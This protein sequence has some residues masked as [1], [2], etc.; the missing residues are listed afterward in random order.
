MDASYHDK[1]GGRG[2]WRSVVGR[3]RGFLGENRAALSALVLLMIVEKAFIPC[4]QYG[5]SN[6]DD[7]DYVFRNPHVVSGFRLANLR[8]AFSSSTGCNWH[9]VTM[10]SHMLDSQL[11]GMRPSGHHLTSVVVHCVNTLLLFLLLGRL[12]GEFWR[13]FWASLFFGVHPLRAES[14]VWISER[15]DVLSVMFFMLAVLAYAAYAAAADRGRRTAFYLLALLSFLLGLMSKP[16]LVTFPLLLL[17]LDY[18]PLRRFQNHRPFQL[19]WEK[20]PMF[21]LSAVFSVVTLITQTTAPLYTWPMRDRLANAI[22]AYCRYVGKLFWPTG[23]APFYPV[24]PWWPPGIVVGCLAFLLG[25]SAAVALLRKRTPF[26]IVGWAWFLVAL[27]PVIG[28]VQVGRQSMADRYSYLPSI[29][30]IVAVVW[31]ACEMRGR[32]R[33]PSALFC[34]MPV[35]LAAALLV[36]TRHQVS[37]WSSNERLWRHAAAVARD[38]DVAYGLLGFI[39]L[40]RSNYD[41]AIT[42]LQRSIRLNH[43]SV[44]VH[45]ALGEALRKRNRFDEALKVLEC[46]ARMQPTNTTAHL[47]VGQILMSKGRSEDA[48][49]NFSF[50]LKLD[51]NNST[52]KEELRKAQR[53]GASVPPPSP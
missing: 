9:P 27:L 40:S 14:V 21:F 22:V 23:L 48:V 30:I 32:C 52:A 44:D 43:D 33:M 39:E 37:F 25:L 11:F 13:S 35:G 38:N 47:R 29:G 41:L 8:S 2:A 6:Y 26:L 15:K 28:L 46:A 19:C 36:A 42:N 45:L 3:T 17:L 24:P 20:A 10:L 7:Q 16:M 51:P 34:V 5:F 31:A 12:T 18:W 1:S 49:T 50:V 4:V 53:A